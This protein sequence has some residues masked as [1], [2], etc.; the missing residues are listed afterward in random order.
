MQELTLVVTQDP[1]AF[2]IVVD[3]APT[4]SA[5]VRV[6]GELDLATAPELDAV[7]N[8]AV[9]GA[10]ETILDLAELA[11]VDMAGMRPVRDA[12]ARGRRVVV[13]HATRQARFLLEAS[14]LARLL[15]GG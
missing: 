15:D 1:S 2:A 10:P 11:F 14:G 13:R 4:G 3:R 12:A 8:G 5:V 9:A 7:L 6:R